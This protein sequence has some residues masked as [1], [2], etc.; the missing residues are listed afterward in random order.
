MTLMN[1]RAQA[2]L[3]LLEERSSVSVSEISK[4]LDLSEVTVRK[5]LD[6]MQGFDG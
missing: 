5:I 2:I 3:R 4:L 6:N 1:D